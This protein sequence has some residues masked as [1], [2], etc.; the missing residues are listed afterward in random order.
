MNCRYE[1][2]KYQYIWE[3]QEFLSEVATLREK[4]EKQDE[5]IGNIKESHPELLI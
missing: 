4:V 2:P 5:L 1:K 3:A